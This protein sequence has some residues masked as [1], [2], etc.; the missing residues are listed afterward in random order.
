MLVWTLMVGFAVGGESRSVAGFQ[1]AYSAV[2]NQTL[3]RF[4]FY[5]RFTPAHRDVLSDH[6]KHALYEVAI[7]HTLTPQLE[8]F[9]DVILANN[10]CIGLFH[11][12]FSSVY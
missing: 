1:R 9:R 7:P 12:T 6:L 11:S 5:D 2:T 4:S 8:Q 10:R 3:A